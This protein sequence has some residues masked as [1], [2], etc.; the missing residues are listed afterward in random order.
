MKFC[1]DRDEHGDPATGLPDADQSWTMAEQTCKAEDKRLCVESEWLFACEGP[2]MLPYPTGYERDA[3]VCNFDRTDLT[4]DKGKLKDLRRPAGELG[5][6]T[7]PFGVRNLVGNVDEWV[8]REGVAYPPFRS[9][10]KGGWWMAAR[11]RCRPATT[12]H[13]EHYRD[14]QTGF[15][16]CKDAS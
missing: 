7:S 12:A 16:C 3:T 14:T 8:V 15:R 5:R 4:D 13:D 1:I 10:L 2:E 11:N 6:C 9:A